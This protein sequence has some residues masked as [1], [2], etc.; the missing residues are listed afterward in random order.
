MLLS[1][2]SLAAAAVLVSAA[3]AGTAAKPTQGRENVAPAWSPDGTRIAFVSRGAAAVDH[4]LWVMRADGTG[5]TNLTPDAAGEGSASWSPD[6]TQLAFTSRAAG[7]RAAPSVEVI[8][9]D[10]RGRRALAVGSF[11]TWSP[12]GAW[13]AYD[14]E[15]G[16]HV[17]EVVG[18]RDRIV[19]PFAP[20]VAHRP[21]W[22]PDGR[23]I[24]Y[25]RENDVWVVDAD[26]S[27]QRRL[28]SHAPGRAAIAPAW[29]PA[30]STIAF[31]VVGSRECARAERGLDRRRRRHEAAPRHARSLRRRRGRLGAG[32]PVAGVRRVEA[33]RRGRRALPRHGARRPVSNVSN[34]RAWDE[35]PTFAPGGGRLAFVIRHGRGYLLSDVW[36]LDLRTSR[37]RNLTGTASGETIDARAVRPPNR[38]MLA[39]VAAWLDPSFARPILRVEVRVSN[40]TRDE[41]RGAVVSVTSG[42]PGLV[43]LTNRVPVTDVH[44]NTEQ[45]FRVSRTDAV[46]VGSRIRV[47]VSARPRAPH[48]P[49]VAIS[50]E[51][52]LRVAARPPLG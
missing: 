38:L 5:S 4:D 26:G 51:L 12:D 22:S 29:S 33:P 28:T 52:N 32:R 40:R 50:R 2:F 48:A 7:G 49:R 6:G 45:A 30:G 3:G 20:T 14:G 18:G 17:L 46:H 42:L 37:R 44:G 19:A 47:L 31:V 8:G 16:L 13:I 1:S 9:A 11:P 34:D 35:T 41:V 36:T 23:R 15:G 10:G 21:S 24:A 39:R 43:P 25:V 27:D